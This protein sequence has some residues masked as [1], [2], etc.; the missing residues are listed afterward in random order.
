MP[1]AQLSF[2]AD[3]AKTHIL[4]QSASCCVTFWRSVPQ[5]DDPSGLSQ[6]AVECDKLITQLQTY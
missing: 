1:R 2:A 6:M 3:V 5:L 4:E